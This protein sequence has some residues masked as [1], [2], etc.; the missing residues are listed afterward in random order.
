[1]SEII[2]FKPPLF[3]HKDQNKL[4]HPQKCKIP[5]KN[6]NEPAACLIKVKSDKRTF[7]CRLYYLNE[8][9]DDKSL[10]YLDDC[11]ELITTESENREIKFINE[12][13]RIKDPAEVS[14]QRLKVKIFINAQQ[15]D[16]RIIKTPRDIAKVTKSLL[17][18]YSFSRDCLISISSINGISKVHVMET[19]EDG[20]GS[21][22]DE[23][24]LDV[25]EIIVEKSSMI[26][27]CNL[28][29]LENIKCNLSS[30]IES[31]INFKGNSF[32]PSSHCL[33]IGPSGSGKTSLIHHVAEIFKCNIFEVSSDVFLPYP[34]KSS[35]FN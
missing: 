11:V 25:D 4:S 33:I 32:K 23:C 17:K 8:V 7:I 5:H 22:T 34:G 28:G 12:I 18:N 21:L 9:Y 16:L 14:F 29:G 24:E 31:N 19:D 35:L 15:L 1:M 26:S 13:Q 6:I 3:I 27:N 10:A 2:N 20:Y 30:F